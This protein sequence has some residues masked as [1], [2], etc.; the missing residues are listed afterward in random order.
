MLLGL[1]YVGRTPSA[2]R[3]FQA[4]IFPHFVWMKT[5]RLVSLGGDQVI[6]R[7]HGQSAD[8]DDKSLLVYEEVRAMIWRGRSQLLIAR[9]DA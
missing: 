6:D 7:C 3:L 8:A 9:N 4:H 5:Y 2:V 1:R